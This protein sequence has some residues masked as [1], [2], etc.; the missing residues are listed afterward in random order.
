MGSVGEESVNIAAFVRYLLDIEIKKGSLVSFEK[1]FERA[2]SVIMEK[3][4]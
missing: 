2:N 4:Q 1:R 3:P